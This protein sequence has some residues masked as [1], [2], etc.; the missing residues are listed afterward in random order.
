MKTTT[1]SAFLAATNPEK[2]APHPRG[3]FVEMLIESF[4]ENAI[5]PESLERTFNWMEAQGWF[6]LLDDGENSE[7]YRLRIY[8]S[9]LREGS[10]DLS[11]VTFR[12]ET[13]ALSKNWDH[14]DPLID[15]RVIS[16]ASTSKDGGRAVIWIDEDGAQWFVHLGKDTHGIISDDPFVFLQ[17][18]AMGYLEPGRLKR[19]N[20]TPLQEA[21]DYHGIDSVDDFNDQEDDD[22]TPTLAPEALQSYLTSEFDLTLPETAHSLGIL[23]FAEYGAAESADPFVKW[24][25]DV[26]P[27][28]PKEELAQIT[29][30]ANRTRSID[31][32]EVDKPHGIIGKIKSFFGVKAE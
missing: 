28:A 29:E 15:A 12:P 16:L 5:L 2:T 3:Q 17:F 10:Q 18:L 14:P 23:D 31:L 4:P 7:D 21:A 25:A 22:I 20:I 9:A 19:T 8:P 13:F 1:I 27:A 30:E 11:Q 26:S 6:D 24:L 32:S